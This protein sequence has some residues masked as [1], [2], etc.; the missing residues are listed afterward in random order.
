MWLLAIGSCFHVRSTAILVKV[1]WKHKI[2]GCKVAK[3]PQEG[4]NLIKHWGCVEG[5]LSI[6][7][8]KIETCDLDFWQLLKIES[9]NWDKHDFFYSTKVCLGFVYVRVKIV[10][11]PDFQTVLVKNFRISTK[12]FRQ[13]SRL[14]ITPWHSTRR[15]LNWAIE[16][17]KNEVNFKSVIKS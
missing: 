6:K 14:E 3:I 12:A 2:E 17:G 11:R 8:W 1:M 16:S 13:S 9:Q 4:F 10:A 5:R 7:P 15:N